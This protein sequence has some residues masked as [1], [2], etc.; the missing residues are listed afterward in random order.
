MIFQRSP[1]SRPQP[2]SATLIGRATLDLRESRGG[3]GPTAALT[4]DGHSPWQRF[5]DL[6]VEAIRYTDE[7]ASNSRRIGA[8]L[9]LPDRCTDFSTSAG[10][11]ASYFNTRQDWPPHRSG[12]EA[13]FN[14][15]RAISANVSHS[16]ACLRNPATTSTSAALTA[17]FR[18]SSVSLRYRER[19]SLGEWVFGRWV[20]ICPPAFCPTMRF[21]TLWFPEISRG[22]L[23]GEAVHSAP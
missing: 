17:D 6:H 4:H 3:A 8:H 1:K 21:G 19:R 16:T 5:R 22:S 2:N 23:K 15:A 7:D 13:A 14:S 9:F 18:A 10:D 11:R 20:A 12:T